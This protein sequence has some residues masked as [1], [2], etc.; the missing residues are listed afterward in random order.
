M[1]KP[2]ILELVQVDM[3]DKLDIERY[4]L[5]RLYKR[6]NITKYATVLQ[7]F[8]RES[9]LYSPMI[10]YICNILIRTLDEQILI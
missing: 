5:Y 2:I 3:N 1:Y 7:K 10:Q 9:A 6:E 4:Q 8:S